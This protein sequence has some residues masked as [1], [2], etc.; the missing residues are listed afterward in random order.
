[1]RKI[2]DLVGL[3][4]EFLLL[5]VLLDGPLKFP[6]SLKFPQVVQTSLIVKG[7]IEVSRSLY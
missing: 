2:L 7:P 3:P 5:E 1:M 6:Q 4:L